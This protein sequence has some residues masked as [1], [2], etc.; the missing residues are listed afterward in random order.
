MKIKIFK[1]S[2][3]EMFVFKNKS[4]LIIF[5]YETM[6]TVPYDANI[7]DLIKTLPKEDYYR[8]T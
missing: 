5:I 7:N 3:R 4:E 6:G 2:T 1:V 8:V